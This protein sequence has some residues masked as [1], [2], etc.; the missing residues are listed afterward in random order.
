VIPTASAP[1]TALWLV[2][3]HRN[4]ITGPFP[5][6]DLARLAREGKLVISDEVCPTGGYWFYLR[7]S[8]EVARVLGAEFS[9]ILHSAVA[10]EETTETQVIRGQTLSGGIA[11]DASGRAPGRRIEPS[12]LLQAFIWVLAILAG[13]VV[14]VVLK[15]LFSGPSLP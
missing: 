12:Q 9:Q 3:S 10:A 14:G 8:E 2:R 7:E 4:E 6:A 1:A 13:L 11:T 15:L 5:L